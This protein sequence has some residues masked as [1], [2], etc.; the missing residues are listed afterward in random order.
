MSSTKASPYS[1]LLEPRITEKAAI[2]SSAN[3]SVVF[4]VHPRA[5]KTEIR[6]A[7]EK[8][9]NVKVKSVRTI[10]SLGKVKRAGAKETR[11]PSTKKAYV[12]LAPGSTI[13]LVDGL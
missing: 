1:I 2:A 10:N 8:I 7:V 13:D 9:F 11:L 4:R 6:H 3:N 5:T 12:S